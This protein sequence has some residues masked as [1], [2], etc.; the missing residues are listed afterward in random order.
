MEV[1]EFVQRQII[2][3][4]KRNTAEADKIRKVY[5]D[6]LSREINHGDRLLE[7]EQ[8]LSALNEKM[9]LS[10]FTENLNRA[11]DFYKSVPDRVPGLRNYLIRNHVDH[12]TALQQVPEPSYK[13]AGALL[14]DSLE[15]L[16]SHYET[17]LRKFVR[18]FPKKLNDR[19][20]YS[21]DFQN[22]RLHKDESGNYVPDRCWSEDGKIPLG[23]YH[24]ALAPFLRHLGFHVFC[25][26]DSIKTVIH[27]RDGKSHS[28]YKL[29]SKKRQNIE[30]ATK[31]CRTR[32][33][34]FDDVNKWIVR[35]A[36]HLSP[37]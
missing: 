32:R 16:Y 20:L 37:S 12:L 34:V 9:G 35:M 28:P 26:S 10:S 14:C 24:F 8:H 22:G 27:L 15:A 30:E 23:K 11:H 18:Q 19:T 3:I 21:Y 7:I 31:K 17:P 2:S 36:Q 33:A 4:E 5:R 6:L 1:I 29:S 25:P 13:K